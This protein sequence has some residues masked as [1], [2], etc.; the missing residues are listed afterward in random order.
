LDEAA[1]SLLKKAIEEWYLSAR[2]YY[3]ILK[4]ARTIAD[5]EEKESI[6]QNHLAEALRY[7]IKSES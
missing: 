6:G 3:K 1:E 5:L 2:A 7:R 4:A